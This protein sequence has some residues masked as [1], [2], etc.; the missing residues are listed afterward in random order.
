MS[1]GFPS[2]SDTIWARGMKFPI[3]EVEELYYLCSKNIDTDQ[4]C[5]YCAADLHLSFCI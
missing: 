1:L 3:L 2:R 4:L 5:G